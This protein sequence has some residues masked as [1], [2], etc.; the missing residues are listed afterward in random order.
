MA[1]D[2]ED[3]RRSTLSPLPD[4]DSSINAGDRLHATWNY[5]GIAVAS[6]TAGE[7]FRIRVDDLPEN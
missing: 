1:I 2:T 3:K 5:R 6:T 7:I 4:A